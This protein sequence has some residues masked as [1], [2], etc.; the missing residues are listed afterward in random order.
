MEPDINPIDTQLDMILKIEYVSCNSKSPQYESKT[1]KKSNG[2][3]V[4][5]LTNKRCSI[6]SVENDLDLHF[7]AF[8]IRLILRQVQNLGEKN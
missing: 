6:I 1:C 4:Q 3:V 7:H 5:I 8:I 2:G